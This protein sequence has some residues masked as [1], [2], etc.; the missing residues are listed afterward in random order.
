MSEK[1]SRGQATIHREV[2][3]KVA[4]SGPELGPALS[5]RRSQDLSTSGAWTQQIEQDANRRGLASAIRA[6]EAE[7]FPALHLQ[8]DPIERANLAVVHDET[9]RADDDFAHGR[10]PSPP[11]NTSAAANVRR[12]N[13]NALQLKRRPLRV[14]TRVYRTPAALSAGSAC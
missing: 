13:V 9:R 12:A 14:S 4:D 3:R 1:R 10:S 2:A 5:R 7:Y 6:K 11:A 8:V